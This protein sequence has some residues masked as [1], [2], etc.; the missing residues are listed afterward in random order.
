M[1]LIAGVV[2]FALRR[3]TCPPSIKFPSP[4]RT[5]QNTL[6]YASTKTNMDFMH[7]T[8]TTRINEMDFGDG[9]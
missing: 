6:D 3:S 4:L 9:T 1:I 7:Q 5:K 8:K 2:T